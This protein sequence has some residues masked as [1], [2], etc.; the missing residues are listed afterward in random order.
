MQQAE[1]K[2]KSVKHR[3]GQWERNVYGK[4]SWKEVKLRVDKTRV[5]PDAVKDMDKLRALTS[6]DKYA[7]MWKDLTGSELELPWKIG[8]PFAPEDE[9]QKNEEEEAAGDLLD[10]LESSLGSTSASAT[11]TASVSE[12]AV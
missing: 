11:L 12:P 9:E 6:K 8:E 7:T 10:D 5:W 2:K 1:E 3:L 4:W